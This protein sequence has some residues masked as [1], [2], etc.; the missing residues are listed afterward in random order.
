MSSDQTVHLQQVIDRLPTDPN[1][2]S[3]LISCA[4]DR[5]RRL[6]KK[7][8]RE[9]FPSLQQAH[10]TGTVLHEG[11]LRLLRSLEEVEVTT[12]GAFFS[13]S[14]LQIRRTLLD[15]A[16]RRKTRQATQ[17]V[18]DANEDSGASTP[19]TD[20]EDNA[21]NPGQLAIWTEFHQKVD[22]LP[23]D[24]KRV[25]DLH[26]YHGLTQ[27]ETAELLEIHPK[28]VSRRWLRARLKLPD[29]AP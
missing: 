21:N 5:L 1:A 8:F 15:L 17:P 16:R 23:E 25:V 11:I 10:D 26:W 24:E 27:A 28:E 20:P 3:E 4:Y 19:S 6:A 22:E 29:W 12:V 14:A 2:R 18:G 13:F 7:I 9:D